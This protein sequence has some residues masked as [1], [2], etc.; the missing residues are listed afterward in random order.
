MKVP[1]PR[2]GALFE[3]A[4][5]DSHLDD[6]S[7]PEALDLESWC[8]SFWEGLG[9]N[10]VDALV[11]KVLPRFGRP[12]ACVAVYGN[13]LAEGEGGRRLRSDF[14]RLLEAAPR[15]GCNLVSTFAGR[16][17]G[18]SVPDSIG[19]FREV[20]APLCERASALGLSIAFENCRFGDT[21]KTGKWNIAMNPDAWE[22]MFDALAGAPIGLEWEPAHQILALADP[23]VQLGKWLP[24]IL[25]IHAKDAHID[26]DLLASRG[27]VGPR[28]FGEERLAG[29]GDANWKSIIAILIEAGWPGSIDVEIGATPGWGGVRSLEG[30]SIALANLREARGAAWGMA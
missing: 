29:E 13:P 30:I 5:L 3:P 1:I 25:H 14:A 10:D 6:G 2:I 26:R 18:A 16:V 22:L 27:M 21:W 19:R 9:E 4:V 23:L 24:R 11:G 12:P 20:F 8:L 15:L 17:P 28:K 7:G